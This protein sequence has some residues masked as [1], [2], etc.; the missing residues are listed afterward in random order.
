MI[1]RRSMSPISM[2]SKAGATTLASSWLRERFPHLDIWTDNGIAAGDAIR[3]WLDEDR[4]TLVL[5]SESQAGGDCGAKLRDDPR[6]VFSL[7][8]RESLF[9][10]PAELLDPSHWPDRVIAMTLARVGGASGPDFERLAE[11]RRHR[12]APPDSMPPVA[13]ADVKICCASR[14]WA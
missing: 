1:L 2:P 8:F 4:G 10:G 12:A 13:C 5:G 11:L 3:R 7:D 6:L 9:Q 14:K